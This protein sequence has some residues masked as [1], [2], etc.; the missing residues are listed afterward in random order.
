MTQQFTLV[1]GISTVAHFS[2]LLL[3]TV[4][5]D[6]QLPLLN[7]AEV[8]GVKIYSSN[9]PHVVMG[10]I[11]DSHAVSRCHA[12]PLSSTSFADQTPGSTARSNCLMHL[13]DTVPWK[14]S[15]T[16]PCTICNSSSILTFFDN[17]RVRKPDR[18]RSKE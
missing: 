9:K 11:R 18:H 12:K 7:T 1:F 10:V 4:Q 6:A 16:S 2:Q 13:W 8:P 5:A 14:A 3:E 17:W 15:E